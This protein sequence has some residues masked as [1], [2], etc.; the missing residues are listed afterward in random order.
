MLALS[1]KSIVNQYRHPEVGEKSSQLLGT[2]FAPF[3]QLLRCI[4]H[5]ERTPTSPSSVSP[6]G[7]AVYF[8][9]Q[10]LCRRLPIVL[11]LMKLHRTPIQC[12]INL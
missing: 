10:A 1:P 7:P 2:D 5:A 12:A 11:P 3:M 6:F 8:P 4:P 9:I